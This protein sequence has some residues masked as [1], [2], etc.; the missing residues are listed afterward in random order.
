MVRRARWCSVTPTRPTGS[1]GAGYHRKTHA[2]GLGRAARILAAADSY[3]AM[4]ERRPHRP[5][6]DAAEAETELLREARE[7]RL[8]PEAADAVLAAAGHGV[9]KRPRELPAGLT[10]RELEVLRAL[11]VL[12]LPL[13]EMRSRLVRRQL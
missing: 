13:A 8:C 1:D 3:Q 2:A 9:A 10:D 12:D 11:A 5:A 7:G 4:R 6:L